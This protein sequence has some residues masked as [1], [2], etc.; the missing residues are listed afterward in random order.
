[1]VCALQKATKTTID[2]DDAGHRSLALQLVVARTWAI[3]G[4]TWEYKELSAAAEKAL[5]SRTGILPS[6]AQESSFT[7]TFGSG[8]PLPSSEASSSSKHDI[9]PETITSFL[10]KHPL[11]HSASGLDEQTIR[12]RLG[13]HWTVEIALKDSVETLYDVTRGDGVSPLLKISPTLTQIENVSMAS[14]AR[15]HR[16][17]GVNDLREALEG[18]NSMS[19]P[20]LAHRPAS[21]STFDHSSIAGD[22]SPYAGARSK[23]PPVA[24][25]AEV[26]D[27]LNRLG[28][29][30]QNPDNL[31][32]AS[33]PA[34]QKQKLRAATLVPPYKT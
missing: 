22:G 16:R 25:G 33:F 4:Q 10:C 21:L 15:S 9:H 27:V 18:R 28:I 29:G 24:R 17:V 32:K 34:L 30:K 20:A 2:S 26:R 3:M 23:R 1:M 8:I 5:S 19:N 6:V 11:V 14:L 7:C 12:D 31:L 13:R